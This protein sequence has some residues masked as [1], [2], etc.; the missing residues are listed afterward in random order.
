MTAAEEERK[1]KLSKGKKIKIITAIV[2]ISFTQGLQYSVS[3]VLGQIQNHFPEVNVSLIQMLITGPA[4]LAMAVAILSGW[5]VVKVSKKKLLIFGSLVAGITGFV[6]F[7]S[8]SFALLFICRILFG[9]GLGLATALNTA[10]VAEFFQGEERVS[11]MGIQAASVGAGMVVIT[12][13]GGILGKFGF[14]NA[15]DTHTIGF[16]A[17]ILIAAMLPETGTAKTSGT[18]KIRLNRK[19]FQISLLGFLEFL[20]LITFTT[21]IAMHISG[22]L[23]GDTGV[24]GTLTGIFSGAQIVMGMV[25]GRITRVTKSGTLPAAMASFA[26][27]AAILV[28]FPDQFVMLMAGAV[29]CGFSQGMFIPTAMVEVANAVPP[30]ATAM[31]SACFTCF[32]CIGQMISPAVLNTLSGV[33]FKDVTTGHVYIIAAA[34]MAVSAALAAVIKTGQAN[35]QPVL[36]KE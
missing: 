28:V 21:N 36:P 34:G 26:V 18:E 10:V 2:C 13:L 7:L 14:A 23:G 24:S 31:A 16:I 9:I 8:D 25:L 35:K 11:V 22:A 32:M 3:P 33:I 19:V 29:F 12:T 1:K 4:L 5:L 15:Y 30:V 6:P 20:F 17:M 27:G